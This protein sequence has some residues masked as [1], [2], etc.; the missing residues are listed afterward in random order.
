[1]KKCASFVFLFTCFVLVFY[2]FSGTS[3]MAGAQNLFSG[4]KSKLYKGAQSLDSFINKNSLLDENENLKQEITY[5]KSQLTADEISDTQNRMLTDALKDTKNNTFPNAINA[6]VS[7]I[8][9]QGGFFITIDKGAKQGIS[10]G[11]VCV[12]GSALVGKIYRVFEN[13]ALVTPITADGCVVGIMNS[14]S[15]S[16]VITG[17]ADLI[18]KN[19]CRLEFFS[20]TQANNGDVLVTSGLSDTYPEGLLAGETVSN[21]DGLFLKTQVDFFKLRTVWVIPS[22]KEVSYG[23][24]KN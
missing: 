5:L 14:E 24:D 23:D 4:I 11:D 15:M 1:M 8:T 16:G 2:A 13:H 17:S 6:S 9:Q 20:N 18:N 22:F 21:E 10:K 19:M 3:Y 12:F 7:A